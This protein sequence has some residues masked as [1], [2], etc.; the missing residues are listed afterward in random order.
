MLE[1]FFDDNGAKNGC[2]ALP[3]EE[4]KISI[5]RSRILLYKIGNMEQSS[6]KALPEINY[7]DIAA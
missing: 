1:S 3:H 2:I 5:A 7:S 4:R 6:P